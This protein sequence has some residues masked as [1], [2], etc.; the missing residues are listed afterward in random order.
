MVQC[1]MAGGMIMR[2]GWMRMQEGGEGRVIMLEGG[3]RGGQG[4]RSGGELD[5]IHAPGKLIDQL[6]K[7]Y[8]FYFFV[9]CLV[10]IRN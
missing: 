3:G 9:F 6:C 10:G 8:D 1:G 4:G 5:V 2:G 7:P